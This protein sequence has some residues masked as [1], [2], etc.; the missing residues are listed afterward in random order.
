MHL[1]SYI[2]SNQIFRNTTHNFQ[3]NKF[4]NKH[5]KLITIMKLNSVDFSFEIKLRMKFIQISSEIKLHLNTLL[6]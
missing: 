1:F 5:T 6:H 4:H 3:V 2:K